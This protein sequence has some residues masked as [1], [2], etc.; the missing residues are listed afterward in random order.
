L[1]EESRRQSDQLDNLRARIRILARF[2]PYLRGDWSK[3]LLVLLLAF[4]QMLIYLFQVSAIVMLTDKGLVAREFGPLLFWGLCVAG[5][6]FSSGCIEWLRRMVIWYVTMKMRIR[7]HRKLFRH[8]HRAPY[9]IYSTRPVGDHIYRIEDDPTG[10]TVNLALLMTLLTGRMVNLIGSFI[11]A[12]AIDVYMGIAIGIFTLCFIGL[13]HLIMTPTRRYSR[14]M[15]DREQE[16]QG[17]LRHALEHIRLI[18]AFGEE[19]R[20]S[21]RYWRSLA[22]TWKA[23]YPFSILIHLTLNSTFQYLLIGSAIIMLGFGGWRH[24]TGAITLGQWTAMNTVILILFIDLGITVLFIQLM[25][26]FLVAA[27]RICETLDMPVEPV[28]PKP[29]SGIR[30]RGEIR[31]DDVVFRYAPGDAPALREVSFR[32]DPGELVALA[33][34]SGSGKSTTVGLLTRLYTAESG[35]ILVDGHDIMALDRRDYLEQTA[36]A[37]QDPILLSGSVAENISFG[38]PHASKSEIVHAGELSLADEFVRRMPQQYET[39]MSESGELS[40]G[41][42]QSLSLGRAICRDA[43]IT[44]LDEA[45]SNFDPHQERQVLENIIAWKEA[46]TVILVAHNLINLPLVDRVVL[47][48]RGRVEAA[49]S[50]QELLASSAL[51]Q[52]MWEKDRAKYAE[53]RSDSDSSGERANE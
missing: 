36:V 11:L 41:Q 18:K 30:V 42:E 35:Q 4:A 50:H 19:K 1:A 52:E 7:L 28:Q 16:L 49:G 46:R 37:L 10:W 38:K 14:M 32:I 53:A 34:P 43:S 33:G 17:H 13:N 3:A 51:Y 2:L 21:I 47:F 8:V 29:E 26:I 25:R 6:V 5:A 27:E 24:I 31:F 44:L 39:E 23:R 22:R 15:Y 45:M 9:N 40:T 20:E 12:V 48:H